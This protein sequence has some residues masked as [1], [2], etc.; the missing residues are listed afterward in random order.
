MSLLLIDKVAL[1]K[2]NTTAAQRGMQEQLQDFTFERNFPLCC[3]SLGN[4]KKLTNL[5]FIIKYLL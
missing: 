4:V 3:S 5:V 2:L 1:S